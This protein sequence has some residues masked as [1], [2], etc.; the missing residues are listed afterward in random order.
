M[1]E[2]FNSARGPAEIG[3]MV[4]GN[5][6]GGLLFLTAVRGMDPDTKSYS[7]DI[8]A[9][10]HQA[11]KNL[12]LVLDGGGAKLEHVAKVTVYIR[13]LTDRTPFHEVWKKY[14]PERPP[15]RLVIQVP[16]PDTVPGRGALFALD[17]VAVDPAAA[18]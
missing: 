8:T 11:F 10:A 3:G 15:A 6:A 14:F 13:N 1:R 5:R 17:V 9:Q 7:S 4:H 16:D 2:V 18:R 12:E